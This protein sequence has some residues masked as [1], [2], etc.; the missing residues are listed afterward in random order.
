MIDF[1]GIKKEIEIINDVEL[2]LLS[3][4]EKNNYLNNINIDKYINEKNNKFKSINVF[5]KELLDFSNDIIEQTEKQIKTIHCYENNSYYVISLFIIYVNFIIDN[6]N[7]MLSYYQNY[8]NEENETEKE[9]YRKHFFE[10]KNLI[11]K[12]VENK[13]KLTTI[14][15]STEFKHSFINEHER[16][17]FNF[18]NNLFFIKKIFKNKNHL[19]LTKEEDN[20]IDKKNVSKLYNDFVSI[21]K[22]ESF[23]DFPLLNNRESYL[24]FKRHSI[25]SMTSFEKMLNNDFENYTPEKTFNRKELNIIK[26]FKKNYSYKN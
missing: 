21:I 1:E 7:K 18:W 16:K 19:M 3:L 14:L 10:Y 5:F 23:F 6:N 22:K 15:D 11:D 17:I 8:F 26:K 20:K 4:K 24:T 9:D 13:N 2:S 25:I 12:I